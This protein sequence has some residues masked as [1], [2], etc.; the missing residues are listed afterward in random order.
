[1]FSRMNIENG[2]AFNVFNRNE[3]IIQLP[4][5]FGVRLTIFCRSRIYSH[6]HFL[7]WKSSNKPSVQKKSWAS[8]CKEH[9]KCIAEKLQT[10]WREGERI[11]FLNTFSSRELPVFFKQLSNRQQ[12]MSKSVN[13]SVWVRKLNNGAL[14]KNAS[15]TPC[16]CSNN[17]WA[18]QQLIAK[19]C[20]NAENEKTLFKAAEKLIW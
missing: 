9:F 2:N 11:V 19:R 6:Y 5:G 14:F 13:T 8:Q 10:V 3:T 4:T 17:S 16:K 12:M 18:K 15:F 7:T 20:W 1:M